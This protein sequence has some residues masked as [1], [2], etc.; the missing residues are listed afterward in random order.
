M[1]KYSPDLNTYILGEYDKYLLKQSKLFVFLTICGSKSNNYLTLVPFIIFFTRIIISILT[2]KMAEYNQIFALMLFNIRF[3]VEYFDIE[4]SHSRFA[5]Y[6]TQ[7][8]ELR[9]LPQRQIS[10]RDPA[11]HKFGIQAPTVETFLLVMTTRMTKQIF[12]TLNGSSWWAVSQGTWTWMLRG[13]PRR[14]RSHQQLQ[15]IQP[16]QGHWQQ[17]KH[18]ENKTRIVIQVNRS[19]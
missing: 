11:L 10:N 4:P 3:E 9:Y 2:Q 12:F 13:R 5:Y 6:S 14:R 19:K 8:P 17:G 16:Q 1:I 15:R 7:K 18:P